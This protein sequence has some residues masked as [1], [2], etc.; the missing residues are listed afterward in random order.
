MKQLT[1]QQKSWFSI[2]VVAMVL[3]SFLVY[4]IITSGLPFIAESIAKQIPNTAYVLLDKHGLESLDQNHF[5]PSELSEA[6]QLEYQQLFQLLVADIKQP[7]DKKEYQLLFRAWD[8]DPNALA[9]ANGSIV[10]TDN[11]IELLENEQ[12]LAAI[13]Y[14]ELGH[15]YHNHSME[16]IVQ[17]SLI[18]VGLSVMFGDI[19]AISSILIEGT[20]IGLNQHYSRKAESEADQFARE[21]LTQR[22]G[23]SEALINVFEKLKPFEKE[24]S[25]NWLNSHPNLDD[26]IKSL[27]KP[28]TP[29]T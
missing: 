17:A 23:N 29:T 8:K 18:S 6:K 19:S 13:I 16:N 7:N 2:I 26:R 27:Q 15:V 14:H 10:F 22:Y 25:F 20:N 3:V 12:Q 5:S 1:E 11:M 4:K 9:L 24:G 28:I 21:Q